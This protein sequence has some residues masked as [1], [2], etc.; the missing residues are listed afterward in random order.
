M[1]RGSHQFNTRR[2]ADDRVG[3]PEG[4]DHRIAAKAGRFARTGSEVRPMPAQ[5]VLIADDE[6]LVRWSL[7]QKCEEWGYAVVEADSGEAALRLAERESPDLVLL[8]VRMPDLTGIEVLD[9]LKKS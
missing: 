8:D 3:F 6:R 9:Q 5:K 7:R 2:P 1:Y 4:W